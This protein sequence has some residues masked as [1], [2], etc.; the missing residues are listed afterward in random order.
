MHPSQTQ[1][2]YVNRQNYFLKISLDKINAVNEIKRNFQIK[3]ENKPLLI[4]W[5]FYRGATYLLFEYLDGYLLPR[6]DTKNLIEEC[7]RLTS[8]LHQQT[9]TYD[10]SSK[11]RKR[12]KILLWLNN[13]TQ[14]INIQKRN[15]LKREMDAYYEYYFYIN[16]DAFTP[17][18]SLIHGDLA[19]NMFLTDNGLY[20]ID[21]E[22]AF[23]FDPLFEI[24]SLFV[25]HNLYNQIA[26][27]TDNYDPPI[28]TNTNFQIYSPLNILK[29]MLWSLK[30]CGISQDNQS[31]KI[32][33]NRFEYL[34]Y[35]LHYLGDLDFKWTVV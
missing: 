22:N 17:F 33:R 8:N 24:S 21:F 14:L 31:Q 26:L 18:A 6:L 2:I 11:A 19:G 16:L 27:F 7:A 20:L 9:L 1:I 34:F 32:L 4:D 30:Y 15:F 5:H 13:Q 23:L 29:D 10:V 3:F 35:N 28:L 25:R 12:N